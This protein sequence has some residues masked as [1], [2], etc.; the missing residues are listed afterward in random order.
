MGHTPCGTGQHAACTHT[1]TILFSL[2]TPT[3]LQ[4]M[5]FSAFLAFNMEHCICHNDLAHI[6]IIILIHCN[7]LGSLTAQDGSTKL[8][9]KSSKVSEMARD[10]VR[11]TILPVFLSLSAAANLSASGSL[12]ST[13][14]APWASAVAKAR[15]STPAPSSGLGKSTVGKSGSGRACST[16][17]IGGGK[18]KVVKAYC[19]HTLTLC[20]LTQLSATLDSSV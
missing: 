12:A 6:T 3:E 2:T 14:S 4:A 7:G 1:N 18:L 19:M 16:T 11:E 10:M 5:P 9:V 13:R 17:G 8:L 20:H 15:S